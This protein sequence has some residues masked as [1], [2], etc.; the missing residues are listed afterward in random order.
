MAVGE[1]LA[2]STLVVGWEEQLRLAMAG[3]VCWLDIG[4]DDP[5]GV[6]GELPCLLV[7]L[8]GCGLR[9]D[10]EGPLWFRDGFGDCG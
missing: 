10:V 3:V 6:A 7:G 9:D 1:D 2:T 8:V 4:L 5:L